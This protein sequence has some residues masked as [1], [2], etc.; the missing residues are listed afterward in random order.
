MLGLA[1]RAGYHDISLWVLEAN[2]RA[3]RF[4]ERAE[5]QATGES[6]VL[7]RLGGITEVRYR[8]LIG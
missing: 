5:F 8:R 7:G 3:R 2:E 4:Y 1:R 6:V